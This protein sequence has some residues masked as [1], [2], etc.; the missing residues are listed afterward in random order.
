[1]EKYAWLEQ[2]SVEPRRDLVVAS[3]AGYV[4]ASGGGGAYASV[5]QL[6]GRDR[7]GSLLSATALVAVADARQLRYVVV[8]RDAAAELCA[9]EWQFPAARCGVHELP[10]AAAC[11]ALTSEIRIEGG[12]GWEEVRIAVGGPEVEYLT[13]GEIRAFRSRWV[14]VD[15]TVEFH[16]P[17]TLRVPSLRR[18][19][20]RDTSG[21]EV[22]LL[23]VDEL[24]ELARAGELTPASR[25][26]VDAGIAAAPPAA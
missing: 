6:H 24:H 2:V 7:A 10:L 18:V 13:E 26:I 15:N 9:G 3:G 5:A 25:A 16:Y 11:R 20:L 21:R 8:R 23:S 12:S 17:M 14:F 4:T 19:A 1:M 22:A